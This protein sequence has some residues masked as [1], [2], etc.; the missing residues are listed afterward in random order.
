[1][2]LVCILGLAACGQQQIIRDDFENIEIGTKREE[3]LKSFGEPDGH[4]S[5]FFG[6]IYYREGEQAIVYYDVGDSGTFDGN[7]I[8]VMNVSISECD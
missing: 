3:V 6:D 2:L 7:D 1:M 5:G 4:L 8:T